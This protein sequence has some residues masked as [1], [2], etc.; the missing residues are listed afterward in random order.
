L[1]NGYYSTDPTGSTGTHLI[2]QACLPAQ[3]PQV[4]L[5]AELWQGNP[6]N[7]NCPTISQY[8]YFATNG[9]G[10]PTF[11]AVFNASSWQNLGTNTNNQWPPYLPAGFSGSWD[12]N[13]LAWQN[14]GSSP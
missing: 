8:Q 4:G 2:G 6:N 14:W 11:D 1:W 13:Y 7:Y 9:S 10:T 5:F 3:T 12:A